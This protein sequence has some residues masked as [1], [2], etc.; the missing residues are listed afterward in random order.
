MG[1]IRAVWALA[2]GLALAGAPA[3]TADEVGKFFAGKRINLLIS[4]GVGGGYDLYA[5]LVAAHMGKHIPGNPTLVPQNQP[6]A[7]GIRVLNYAYNQAPRDGTVIFTLH[8]GLPLHQALARDGVRYD[9]AKIIGVGRIT[10]GNSSTGVWKSAGVKS[11]EDALKTEVVVGATQSSSNSAVFPTVGAVI[12]GAKIRVVTGYKSQEEVML[13]MERGEVQGFGSEA[14]ASM[15]A[16][17]PDYVNGVHYFPLFQW[18]LKREKV[19][20]NVPLA[21]ELAKNEIDRR[22]L[23]VLSAQMDIGRSYYLPP[24]VPQDRVAALRAAFTKAVEDPALV[25]AAKTARAE[26]RYASGEETEEM[27]KR[28]LTAPKDALE[29]LQRAMAVKSEATC[30]QFTE[31]SHCLQAK[32]KKKSN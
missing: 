25:A 18:G 16:A 20:A 6:G 21:S 24:E 7:G 8:I 9:T 23:E 5:R 22:A 28:V 29:R 27:I 2:G 11:F 13:A 4:T 32:P 10:A 14:L 3:A 15:Q 26:I 30:E 19:W 1:L 17:H 31:K 12:L